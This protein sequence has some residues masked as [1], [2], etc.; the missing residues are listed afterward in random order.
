M[1]LR[2]RFLITWL[3]VLGAASF[4]RAEESLRTPSPFLPPA[5]AAQ[6]GGAAKEDA[7][8]QLSGMTVVGRDTLLSITRME[9][10][11]SQWIPVG[12]TVAEI[13]VVSYDP[14][15]E[16]AVIRVAGR[17]HRLTLKKA[18]V[19]PAPAQPATVPPPA[20]HKPAPPAPT[21]EPA[22]VVLPPM[23]PQ[24]EKEM[25]ARM[26]VSDLLEIGQQQRQAYAEA[27]RKAAQ[28]KAQR[29]PAEDEAKTAE[30]KQ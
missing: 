6:P 5:G 8:F 24:E 20:E 23:T 4:A 21:K 1:S 12:K 30:T 15:T 14:K 28:E 22:A 7:A 25:E 2:L 13:T 9:D 19:Q 16:Q 26:L 10:K 29:A 27:R 11:R 17:E 18:S 3:V